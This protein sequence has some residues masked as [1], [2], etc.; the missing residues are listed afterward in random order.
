MAKSA[1]RG[2]RCGEG[3]ITFTDGSSLAIAAEA[4]QESL[5]AAVAGKARGVLF[6]HRAESGRVDGLMERFD[7]KEPPKGWWDPKRFGPAEVSK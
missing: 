2:L 5:R 1:I 6:V 3:R 7:G 4:S